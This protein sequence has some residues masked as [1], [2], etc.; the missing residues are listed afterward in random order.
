[1]RVLLWTECG[2]LPHLHVHNLC[3]Y[4]TPARNKDVC[5]DCTWDWV[6]IL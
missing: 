4:Q 1:M 2:I 3:T 6:R 5:I